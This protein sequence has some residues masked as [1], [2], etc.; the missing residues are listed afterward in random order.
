M[1]ALGLGPTG[2]AFY[3]WDHAV[4]R[5]DIRVLGALAYLAP[6][7]STGLLLVFGQVAW[8]LELGVA[9]LLVVAGAM[10]AARDMLRRW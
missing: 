8:S 2:A 4:K 1:A 9:T 10:L 5:G 6:I 7:L 3:L